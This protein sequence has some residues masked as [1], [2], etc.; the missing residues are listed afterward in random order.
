MALN[1]PERVQ[2]PGAARPHAAEDCVEP[3]ASGARS[4]LLW[5]SLWL[6]VLVL[7]PVMVL[8]EL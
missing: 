3:A 2:V 7:V 1:F 8:M 6:L 4:W 5:L